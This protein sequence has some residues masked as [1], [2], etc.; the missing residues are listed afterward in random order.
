MERDME[1]VQH[2]SQ[3]DTTTTIY[4]F[5]SAIHGARE[6]EEIS[7]DLVREIKDGTIA[8]VVFSGRD[9]VYTSLLRS[10]S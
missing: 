5:Y 2:I 10:G 8:N 9:A 1:V 6:L 3:I 7:Y 4:C